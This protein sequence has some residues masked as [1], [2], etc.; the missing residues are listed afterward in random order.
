M[1]RMLFD[2]GTQLFSIHHCTNIERHALSLIY[3]EHYPKNLYINV[4]G[5][6]DI[7]PNKVE[8]ILKQTCDIIVKYCGGKI[9][10][11]GVET[12]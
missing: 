2:R 11:T 7:T 12:V 6:F 4:D 1:N 10:L 9:E 3:N 8:K 5:I